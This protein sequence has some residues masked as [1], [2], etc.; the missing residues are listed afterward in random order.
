MAWEPVPLAILFC[1]LVLQRTTG[2]GTYARYVFE[3]LLSSCGYISWI[4]Y[5]LPGTGTPQGTF[6]NIVETLGM[7]SSVLVE[8]HI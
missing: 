5:V 8:R 7:P 4:S 3:G 1:P 2:A 6:R